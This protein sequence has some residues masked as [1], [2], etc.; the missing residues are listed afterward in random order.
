MRMCGG[1]LP[2]SVSQPRELLVHGSGKSLPCR[3]H[4]PVMVG[5]VS[6]G[7]FLPSSVYMYLSVRRQSVSSHEAEER[8][9][10]VNPI[11]H[12]WLYMLPLTVLLWLRE[13]W[14]GTKQWKIPHPVLGQ[15]TWMGIVWGRGKV[16]RVLAKGGKQGL[17]SISRRLSSSPPW[18]MLLL[19]FLLLKQYAGNHPI[20]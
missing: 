1:D 17:L 18:L 5:R 7:V 10:N 8:G 3:V 12:T 2:G 4:E 19:L 13:E 9:R 14:E 16:R 6:R 15:G 11:C 20:S